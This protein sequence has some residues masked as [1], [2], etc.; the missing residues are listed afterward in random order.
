MD[1]HDVGLDKAFQSQR[2]ALP[3]RYDIHPASYTHLILLPPFC[4]VG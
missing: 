3:G 2:I 1:K 4:A